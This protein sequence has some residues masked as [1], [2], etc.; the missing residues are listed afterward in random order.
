VAWIFDPGSLCLA[1]DLSQR[2]M[3]HA[4]P[5]QGGHYESQNQSHS[6]ADA[7]GRFTNRPAFIIMLI[8]IY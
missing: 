6:I 8:F 1:F 7:Q 4:L 3:R 2:E 5:C